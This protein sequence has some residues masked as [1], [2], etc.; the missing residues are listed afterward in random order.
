MVFHENRLLAD[1]SHEISYLIFRKLR[2]MLQNLSSAAV[3]IGALR[4]NLVCSSFFIFLF[5][6]SLVK[7]DK[8]IEINNGQ[9]IP[10]ILYIFLF[11][12]FLEY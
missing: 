12:Y 2:K 7:N 1:D 8:L 11:S 10:L 6:R 9:P 5:F 3:V 4:V